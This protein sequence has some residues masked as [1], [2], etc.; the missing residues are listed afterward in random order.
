MIDLI[1]FEYIVM[2]KNLFFFKFSSF[3]FTHFYE[4]TDQGYK[5]YPW[6]IIVIPNDTYILN[7]IYVK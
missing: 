4:L 5:I 7:L 6:P 1:D 3:I 2:N